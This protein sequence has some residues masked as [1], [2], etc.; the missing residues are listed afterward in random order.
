MQS[1]HKI[2]NEGRILPVTVCVIAVRSFTGSI[3]TSIGIG[4]NF[5]LGAELV[6]PAPL[7]GV[8]GMPPR[9]ILNLTHSEI[10]S[11]AILQELDDM[12]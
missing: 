9:K 3:N 11:R 1:V 2:V 4:S 10:V 5:I 8:W 6:G 7:G 12:L